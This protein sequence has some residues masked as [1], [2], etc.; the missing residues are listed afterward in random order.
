MNISQGMYISSTSIYQQEAL[1]VK[2]YNVFEKK[3]SGQN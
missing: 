1:F 2:I 3:V